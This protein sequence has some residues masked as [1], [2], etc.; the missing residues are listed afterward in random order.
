F[1]SPR[2]DEE[3]RHLLLVQVFLDCGVGGGAERIE[4]KQHAV[5]LDQLARL[6]HRLWRAVAVVVRDEVDL[7]P[8]DA[9]LLVQHLEEGGL[10]L[11][12]GPIGGSG[13]AIR[14]DVANLDLGVG[15][16]G[17]VLLFGPRRQ[18]RECNGARRGGENGS[19]GYPFQCD[20]LSG[21]TA[22]IS[23]AAARRAKPAA[24]D[25]MRK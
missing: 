7:A 25:G 18:G 21:P 20:L 6:L 10:R 1:G 9:A 3:L 4:N 24:P 17:A 5:L 19:T 23:R 12:N 15:N 22:R 16:A 2:R 14:H 8:I 13:T 11:T